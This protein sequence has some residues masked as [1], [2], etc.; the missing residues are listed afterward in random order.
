MRG[1]WEQLAIYSSRNPHIQ[2]DNNSD[3]PP[4]FISLKMEFMKWQATEEGKESQEK[5]ELKKTN[6][7]YE[8]R[9]ESNSEGWSESSRVEKGWQHDDCSL[10]EVLRSITQ[11]VSIQFFRLGLM[12]RFDLFSV[13]R[14]VVAAVM[15]TFH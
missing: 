2:I 12:S 11:L 5:M 6:E 10:L 13:K 15:P 3:L 4:S 9:S 7:R 1:S 8:S 14:E